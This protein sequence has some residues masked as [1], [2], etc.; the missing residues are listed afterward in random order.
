LKADP[1][2]SMENFTPGKANTYTQVYVKGPYI[3]ITF[4]DGPSAEYT[5]T[6]LDELKK[7][8]IK[9]TFFMVG[10]C[11]QE[12]PQLVKRMVAEGHE[13][14][15]H[16]WSH[17]A[18]GKMGD[19]AVRSELQRTQDAI[20]AACGVKPTLMRP[21]Y[22]SIT[23]A[24]KRWIPEEMGLQVILWSVD[25]LDW[26]KPGENVLRSRIVNGAADGAII[27]AHDIHGSTVRAMPSTFD[28]LLAK[29]YKFATVS[30]LLAMELPKPLPTP[31]VLAQASPEV[32][33][34]AAVPA[35]STTEATEV[36]SATPK[37]K[38]V[39]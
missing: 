29:G 38:T 26:K 32:M 27:L 35:T 23:Q 8:N 30:E 3:A 19:A 9:A 6:L 12:F 11:V 25:P 4:D 39:Q 16:S 36:P 14:A 13:V 22:G 17:P 24:Q 34:P 15:N 28:E 31:K 21:P 5:G 37:P 18:F 20:I 10:Q 1:E 2:I 33:T 7:R